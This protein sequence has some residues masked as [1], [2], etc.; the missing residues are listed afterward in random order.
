MA[1][2]V[3]ASAN[4]GTATASTTNG[5]FL[6]S[7]AIDGDR[8]GTYPDYWNDDT[9]GGYDDWLQVDFSGSNSINEIDVFSVQDN[10]SAPVTPTLTTTC[11][12]YGLRDFDAQY[13]NGSAW[14]TVTGGSVTGNT[15]VWRRFTFAAVTTTKIRVLVH[16][17]QDGAFTRIAEVEAWTSA[18]PGTP[19]S[20]DP[21]DGATNVSIMPTFSWS[22]PGATTFDVRL[23]TFN[24]PTTVVS[25]GQAG[26]TY[27]P[28]TRA[29]NT[30]YFWRINAING[31]GSTLGPVWS[32]TTAAVA[33]GIKPDVVVE[34][35]LSGDNN[36]WTNLGKGGSADVLSATGLIMRYGI[37]GSGPTDNVAA[38]GHAQFSLDNSASNSAHLLGLYSLYNANKLAGW[39]LDIRCRITLVNP[40]SGALMRRF[41]GRI[42]AIDPSPGKRKDRR[43]TVTVVDWLDEAANWSMDPAIGEQVNKTWT[44][45]LQAIIAQMPRPPLISSLD[46]GI[47]G[48]P[49]ALDTSSSTGQ[50]ALA[51]F[52][53][54]ADSER[55]FIYQKADGTLKAEG[56]HARLLNTTSVWTLTENDLVDLSLP[57]TRSEIIDTFDVTIHPRVVDDLPTSIVYSQANVIQIGPSAN[58]LLLGSYRDAVTGDPIGAV[59]VQTPD[60]STPHFDYTANT[61]ADGSGTNIT[62]DFSVVL[63]AGPAGISATVTNGNAATGY[64]TSFQLRGRAVKDKALQTLRAT[65]GSG[66]HVVPL[67]MPYQGN[68]DVGQGAADYYLAKYDTAYAQART[69]GVIGRTTTLL[70]QLLTRDISDRITISETVTGVANDFFINGVE[71]RVLPTCVVMGIYTLAPAQD[72]F[73]G[74]YW[75]LGTSTLGTDTR[76]APF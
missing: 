37:Q 4:G 11:A 42:D 9:P 10:V 24:P 62:A 54:L 1:T 60:P 75:V 23:D 41:I 34:V 74:L 76:P 58:Q 15:L 39:A 71:L 66:K 43:V 3:A 30:T 28:S 55:G 72:P 31:S 73:S 65:S 27:T 29:S 17:T 20:P 44:Q 69:I 36:G 70:T 57:S 49:I 53:K 67:D 56:R 18:V 35:E 25:S 6:A 61:A 40:V 64:L 13:W 63:Q 16:A 45:V 8:L 38:S 14:V 50:P 19:T 12:I 22:G 26:S 48:Y 5:T 7:K 2:N 68:S 59:D 51:E 46:D 52:K 33:S 21:A 32:F 47:E